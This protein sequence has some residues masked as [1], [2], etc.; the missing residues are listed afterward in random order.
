MRVKPVPVPPDSLDDLEGI[1][2]AVPLVPEPEASCC[3]RL[4]ARAGIDPEDASDWLTFLRG[5]GLVREGD[6]GFYR[7]REDPP[8]ED[9]L[10]SGIYGVR[11][12]EGILRGSEEPLTPDE[13][14]TRFEAVPHWERHRHR[15]PEAV[16]RE[17]VGRLAGWLALVGLAKRTDRGYVASEAQS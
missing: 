14:A 15:D 1:R 12:V 17:R 10:R 3:E 5:L 2:R 16:W 6:S 9:A 11:E 8:L 13:I 4:A 7:T